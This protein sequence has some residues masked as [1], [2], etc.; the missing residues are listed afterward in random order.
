MRS[1]PSLL[2]LVGNHEERFSY[3]KLAEAVAEYRNSGG[4]H[5]NPLMDLL[6]Y[7][8]AFR[9]FVVDRASIPREAVDFLF[10]RPF[11]RTIRMHGMIVE[12][13]EE[14]VLTLRPVKTTMP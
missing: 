14:G 9:P 5:A 4:T 2:K 7:E 1:K 6:R 8:F 3:V 13:D 11:I 10:G 12:P